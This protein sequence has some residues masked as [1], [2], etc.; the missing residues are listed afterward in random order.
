MSTAQTSPKISLYGDH[1]ILVDWQT[2]GFSEEINDKVHSLSAA[3]RESRKYIEVVPGYDSLVCVFDLATRS[4][5][6]TK[7]HI[8]DILARQNL[9]ATQTGKLI[10]IPVH[11]GGENGPDMETICASAK[12]S[13]D[14]VIARHSRK[15]RRLANY[16]AHP[17]LHF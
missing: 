15:P 11:Y 8:E 14:K 2:D 13:A 6:S 17:A 10:D 9:S 5:V 3:L 16:R 12:L 7:R 1:A 4:V